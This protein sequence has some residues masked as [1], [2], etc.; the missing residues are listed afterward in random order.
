MPTW[1]PHCSR[2]LPTQ[3]FPFNLEAAPVPPSHCPEKWSDLSKVTHLKAD[4]TFQC[5]SP[6]SLYFLCST[7]RLLPMN[8]CYPGFKN[9]GEKLSKCPE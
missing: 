5:I 1:T 6:N 4:K 2:C 8:D 7:T 9:E 3:K